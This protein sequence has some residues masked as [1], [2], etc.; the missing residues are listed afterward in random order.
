MAP[1]VNIFAKIRSTEAR[2]Q[3]S[4]N[5]GVCWEN[6]W[7]KGTPNN[8][9]FQWRTQYLRWCANCTDLF[10]P[11]TIHPV[12]STLWVTW[13]ETRVFWGLSLPS[14][15]IDKPVTFFIIRFLYPCKILSWLGIVVHL[16]QALGC[17]ACFSAGSGHAVRSLSAR[18]HLQDKQ[19][20][21]GLSPY[22]QLQARKALPVA[23]GLFCLFSLLPGLS[24]CVLSSLLGSHFLTVVPTL[25]PLRPCVIELDFIFPS[26][27][28]KII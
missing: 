14:L 3:R 20:G 19:E 27:C 28:F 2:R 8:P 10:H 26:F 6:Q 22:Q 23:P 11:L 5:L 9:I 25:L 13:K 17:I 18:W 15:M 7:P 12:S 4:L 1:A 16:V 24:E 21:T